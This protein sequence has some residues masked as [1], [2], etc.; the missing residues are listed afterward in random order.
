VNVALSIGVTAAL[1]AGLEGGARLIEKRRAPPREVADYIWDWDDKMP[2]GFYVMKSD[3]A[4]WPPWEE[5]NRDGLRDRTRSREKP[6][7]VW[8]VAV[9]GDSVTLGAEVRPDQAYPRMMETRLRASGRRIEVMNVALW[10]WSTRQERTAWQRIARA[11]HPDQAI[12]AVCLN[13]VPELQN[14]L[15][16]P[17]RWLAHLHQR[18]AVVRLVVD[19]RSREIDSVE[20]LFDEADAPRVTE[21]LGRFFEEIRLLRR[22]VEPEGAAFAIVVFPFRF[23]VEPGA[24]APVVQQRIAQFCRSEGLRCLDMLP[25]LS[26]RGSFSF[27]DYDHLSPSGASLTAD[28][29]LASA[30][31]PEG[32]SNPQA[33]RREFGGRSDAGARGIAGWLDAPERGMPAPGI[34]ALAGILDQR[35][36]RAGLSDPG[37]AEVRMAAAWALESLGPAA[38][39]AGPALAWALHSDSSTGVRSA[40]AEAIGAM[41]PAGREVVPALFDA[42][43]DP[44]EAVR[45]AVAQALARLG[46][47]GED[48]PHL[49]AVLHST[50][51]YVAAF[52]AWSLGNLRAEAKAAVP[53]LV[54]ALDRDDVA[55]VAA[56]ALARIGPAAGE[57]V[58][59]LVA[60]LGS[61]DSGR[62]WRA[63]RT[64]GRIGPPA[65]GAV[66]ALA[67]ALGD[68]EPWVRANAAKALG[69]IGAA[70]RSAA[71]ALQRA[72]GDPDAG[73]RQEARQALDHLH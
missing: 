10:G 50:D 13:D 4:G 48:V 55:V 25:A 60:A 56:G 43:G 73:V 23:Q 22:E 15:S 53:A 62:R 51:G 29:L 31:L 52:A 2:G 40:A 67:A 32:Y 69:R 17:P 61:P 8:R 34:A 33:L 27:L 39:Q 41:G 19:A 28:T 14:N 72:T 66:A 71:P 24:P 30:L 9:L 46:P 5:F 21:A 3:A 16:R 1:L 36:K 58:P 65:E 42:L 54:Q 45:S 18:S 70:A 63:A 37:A 11:Y 26:R 7:G 68:P 12:L 64:L 59:S 44:S 49:L 6:E 38:T 35:G 47:T 20:R 57:A